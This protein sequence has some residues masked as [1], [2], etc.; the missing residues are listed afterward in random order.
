[1]NGRRQK[2]VHATRQ[3]LSSIWVQRAVGTP[4]RVGLG[5]RMVRRRWCRRREAKRMILVDV[6]IGLAMCMQH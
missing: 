3:K 5:E 4:A 6:V 1:M 2:M